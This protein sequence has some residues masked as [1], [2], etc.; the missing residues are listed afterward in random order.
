[1]KQCRPRRLGVRWDLGCV[2]RYFLW[3]IL[4]PLGEAISPSKVGGSMEIWGVIE[5]MVVIMLMVIV[6]AM[7]SHVIDVLIMCWSGVVLGHGLAQGL[8][9]D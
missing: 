3:K 9:R 1:M 4:E 2:S 8:G 5:D 7:A 6:R